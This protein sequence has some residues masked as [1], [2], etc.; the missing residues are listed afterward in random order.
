MKC[1]GRRRLGRAGAGVAGNVHLGLGQR[2]SQEAGKHHE[3]LTWL[4][5]HRSKAEQGGAG[6]QPAPP[7]RL[8]PEPLTLLQL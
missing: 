4:Q 6:R 7:P 3:G 2:L 5:D 8:R 1:E